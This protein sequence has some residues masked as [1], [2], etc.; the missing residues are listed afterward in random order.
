MTKILLVEDNPYDEELAVL[1]LK[2]N[3]PVEKV[4]ISRD[5]AQALEYLFGEE[6]QASL[7]SLKVVLLDIKLPKVDGMEVLRRIR[8]NPITRFLPVVMLSSSNQ[9]SDIQKAYQLGANSYIV[10]PV[11]FELFCQALQQVGGYWLLLNQL[12]HNPHQ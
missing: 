5:G 7:R 6:S 11:N 10:K 2:T 9:E 1:A 8:A 4:A 12:P 3:Q